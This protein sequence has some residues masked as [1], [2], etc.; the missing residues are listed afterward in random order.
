MNQSEVNNLKRNT[1]EW[2]KKKDGVN[3]KRGFFYGH[4][5]K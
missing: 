5:N 3:E 2:R 1:G 4:R